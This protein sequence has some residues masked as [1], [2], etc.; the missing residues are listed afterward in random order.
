MLLRCCRPWMNRDRLRQPMKM[1]SWC[2]TITITTTIIITAF[3]GTCPISSWCLIATATTTTTITIIITIITAGD[4]AATTKAGVA[5]AATAA[6][7]TNAAAWRAAPAL[8][9]RAAS[10]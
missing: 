3:A 1:C 5:I 9:S 4:T 2:N 6:V 10:T 7:T 8:C